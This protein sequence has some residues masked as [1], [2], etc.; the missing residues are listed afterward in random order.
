MTDLRLTGDDLREADDCR[1]DWPDVCDGTG[2]VVC[3]GCGGDFCVCACGGEWECP[4][5]DECA[6]VSDRDYEPLDYADEAG[7]P[8]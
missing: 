6:D 5:C 3:Q 1:C 8:E 7:A 4:G 2:M